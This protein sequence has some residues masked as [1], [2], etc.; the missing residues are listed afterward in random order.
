MGDVA[1]AT[2]RSVEA[3]RTE[4]GGGALRRVYNPSGR[5]LTD[6][7]WPTYADYALRVADTEPLRAAALAVIGLHAAGVP[8]SEAAAAL[9]RG[10]WR[11]VQTGRRFEW[12]D[13][14]ACVR[15][16]RAASQPPG[17]HCMGY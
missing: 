5:L 10:P 12:D 3:E 15:Y 17:P 11:D 4:R 2:R 1:P 16:E 8:R 7:A 14:N 13:G 9:A 6:I